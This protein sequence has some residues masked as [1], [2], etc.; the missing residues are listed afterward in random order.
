M[1]VCHTYGIAHS[2][3]L[4]WSIEDRNKAVAYM[5]EEAVR[6]QMCGTADWEWDPEQ[7]GKRLA[8]EPVEKIC[9]GCYYKHMAGEGDSSMPGSSVTLVPTSGVEYARSLVARQ[10]N[11]MLKE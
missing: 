1:R 2:V 6:C 8:Y 3:F 7:G 10:R 4:D 5:L 9:W 11:Q